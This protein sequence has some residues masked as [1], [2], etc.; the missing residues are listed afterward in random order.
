MKLKDILAMPEFK[1]FKV[2][3][4]EDGLDRKVDIVTVM[5]APDQK[6]DIDESVFWK[7]IA[8]FVKTAHDFLK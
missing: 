2:L 3:A 1:D 6:F 7:G 5:D 8:L 4:G